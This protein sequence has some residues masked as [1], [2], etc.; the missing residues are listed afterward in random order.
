[1]LGKKRSPKAWTSYLADDDGSFTLEEYTA[2]VLSRILGCLVESTQA[3]QHLE[4]MLSSLDDTMSETN[5]TYRRIATSRG[6][7]TS[8]RRGQA[9][10][11]ALDAARDAQ[12]AIGAS[13]RANGERP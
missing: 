5:E 6:N 13:A 10:A 8:G 11:A 2:A 1:M 9:D 12:R 3:T 4:G 7:G